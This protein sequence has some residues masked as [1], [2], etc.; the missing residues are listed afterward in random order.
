VPRDRAE[1]ERWFAAAAAQ[2]AEE[3]ARN[4]ELL[5]STPPGALPPRS[6]AASGLHPTLAAGKCRL[7]PTASTSRTG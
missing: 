4:L 1:A 5:R 2:G 6:A 7:R 3:A